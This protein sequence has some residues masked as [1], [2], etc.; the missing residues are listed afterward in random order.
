MRCR[1]ADPDLSKVFG[2]RPAIMAAK[3]TGEV[4]G[5]DPGRARE[6]AH[7]AGT[8]VLGMQP[9]TDLGEPPRRTAFGV[10]MF[11][12]DE[13]QQIHERRLEPLRGPFYGLGAV[14][15]QPHRDAQGRGSRKPTPSR[16]ATHIKEP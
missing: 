4:Y 16:H 10:L 6:L 15:E 1:G 11:P 7:P 13:Q 2:Y 3:G 14:T 9:I 8:G 5:V 12:A